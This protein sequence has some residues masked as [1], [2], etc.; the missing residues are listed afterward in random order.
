[1]NCEEVKELLEAYALGALD[2]DEQT[3][4][5]QHLAGCPEH[6]T[7]VRE[8][9]E[10][11]HLLPDALAALSSERLPEASKSRLLQSIETGGTVAAVETAPAASRPDAS[12]QSSLASAPSTDGTRREA[13][14]R[15]PGRPWLFR[16]W[17]RPASLI[18]LL[19]LAV[20]VITL[21][22]HLTNV[23]AQERALRTEL[24]N[25]VDQQEIVLEVVD[26]DRAVRRVLL[27]PQRDPNNAALPYGKLFTHPDL[28][29]VVAMIARLPQPPPGQAYHLWLTRQGQT[30]LAGVMSVNDQGFSLLVFDEDLDGPTYDSA[31]L[32]PQPEGSTIPTGD[33]ILVWEQ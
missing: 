22:I 8:L 31:Q 10:V 14:N 21:G 26:S 30:E 11:A 25:L 9:L 13:L 5:E 18:A 27:P 33:P 19:V 4:V 24:A 23:L 16:S 12:T 3:E 28:S 32:I 20:I 7:Q 2:A 29:H 1:M 17:M 6:Q 15:R